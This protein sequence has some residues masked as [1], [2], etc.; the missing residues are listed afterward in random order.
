MLRLHNALLAVK[1]SGNTISNVNIDDVLATWEVLA[2]EI[3][4]DL[5]GIQQKEAEL[6]S[7]KVGGLKGCDWYQCPLGGDTSAPLREMMLCSGCKMV[8]VPSSLAG[9]FD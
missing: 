3:H 6:R 4:I 8:S 9:S 5:R 7:L 2:K 1:R